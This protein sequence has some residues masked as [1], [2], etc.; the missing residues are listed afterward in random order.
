MASGSAKDSMSV[1]G[2]NIQGMNIPTPLFAGFVDCFFDGSPAGG[3]KTNGRVLGTISGDPPPCI[4]SWDARRAVCIVMPIDGSSL[5]TVQPRAV[6]P[7]GDKQSKG[8]I[9]IVPHGSMDSCTIGV[10]R[11]LPLAVVTVAPSLQLAAGLPGR[12]RSRF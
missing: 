12:Y 8:S 9:C 10:T 6:A 5:V 3:I 11:S 7:E 1:V 4:I 2:P